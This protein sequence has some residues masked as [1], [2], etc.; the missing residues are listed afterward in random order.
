MFAGFA[1]V[2]STERHT[3]HCALCFELNNESFAL[4]IIWSINILKIVLV[5]SILPRHSV[6]IPLLRFLSLE[7]YSLCS[8]NGLRRE[9]AKGTVAV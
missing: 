7:G 2:L 3:Q 8:P 9:P 5:R 6:H 1:F 4:G